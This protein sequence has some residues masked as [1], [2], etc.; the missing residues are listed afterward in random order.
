MEAVKSRW[1]FRHVSQKMLPDGFEGGETVREVAYVT[2]AGVPVPIA[3]T[4]GS[5]MSP[6][7][8]QVSIRTGREA[9][10]SQLTSSR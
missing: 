3:E 6:F 8:S 4:G 5:V 7:Y 10:G 9:H 1:L 2:F